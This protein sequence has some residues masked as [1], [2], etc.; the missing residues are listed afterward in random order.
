MS[1]KLDAITFMPIKK[2][3]QSFSL[4]FP[5][6]EGLRIGAKILG[7]NVANQCNHHYIKLGRCPLCGKIERENNIEKESE[8]N[9]NEYND[10]KG[11]EGDNEI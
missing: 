6:I 2:D 4:M 11:I 7:T 3:L 8:D 10:E 9:N 1:K 5:M